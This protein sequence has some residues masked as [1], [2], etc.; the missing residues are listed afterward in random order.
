MTAHPPRL[1]QSDELLWK[2]TYS[3]NYSSPNYIQRR[4][5]IVMLVSG[6]LWIWM[7]LPKASVA[8]TQE[9]LDYSF[10]IPEGPAECTL[11]IAAEQADI[12]LMFRMELVEGLRTPAIQGKFTV[13]Q[14]FA[15]LLLH[16]GLRLFEDRARGGYAVI[17]SESGSLREPNP[18]EA[19][20]TT[21]K[22]TDNMN[23]Y[24][25]KQ[26][27]FLS[28]LAGLVFAT[29]PALTAQEAENNANFGPE[30]NVID[31]EAFVVTGS[32]VDSIV[33]A[34]EAK[35][36]AD[37]TVEVVSAEDI[38]RLPDI[39]VA[40][41]LSRLPGISSQRTSGQSS[42]INIRGL[43]QQL[44]FATLNGREQVTQNGNRSVEFEQYP[45]ELLV[46]AKVYKSPK[47]SLIEG[48]IGGTIELQTIRPLAYNGRKITVNAR[49]SYSDRAD[50][51]YGAKDFGNRFSVSY[52]DQ[53][54]NKTLGIAFGYARLEQ[55]DIASRFVGF[56]FTQ[57]NKDFDMD[58][59]PDVVSF[60]FDGE[61]SGGTDR[62]NGLMSTIQ[63]RP[64]DRFSLVVDAYYSEFSSETFKRQFGTR[65][66]SQVANPAWVKVED[67]VVIGDALVGGQFTRL[68]PAGQNGLRVQTSVADNSDKDELLSLGSKFAY[69]I[70]ER[71]DA[72]VDISYSKA[73]SRA[74]NFV[75]VHL[76]LESG[77]PTPRFDRNV[78]L[79]F[80]LNGR[81]LPT[82]NSISPDLGDPESM[83]LTSGNSSPTDNEDELFAVSGDVNF[84]L[85]GSFISGLQMGFRYSTRDASQLRNS[86]NI[87]TVNGSNFSSLAPIALT[88]ENSVT[89][90]FGGRFADA[91]FPSFATMIDP[92][93]AIIAANGPIVFQD[94]PPNFVLEGSFKIS[95]DVTAG[96][97][98]T[99]IDTEFLGV[100]LRG[101][102]GLRVVGTEQESVAL[103][104]RAPGK[105]RY[106]RVLPAANFVFHLT[107]RDQVRLA[108]SR[109]ITRPPIAGLGAGFA[110]AFNGTTLV[111][112]GTGNP[113]LVPFLANQADISYERY[114]E[115]GGAF[116]I[117]AFYKNL[118]S[119]IARDQDDSFDFSVLNIEDFLSPSDLADWNQAGSPVVG[120]QNGPVNGQGGYVQGVEVGYTKTFDSLPEPFDG[121]GIIANYSYTESEIEFASADSGIVRNSPL[122]GLST[123]VANMTLFYEK[124]GFSTRAGF[125][126]RSEFVSPQQALGQQLPL[127]D[128]ETVIDYQVSYM[129]RSG[130]MK[131]LT[132]LLQVNNLTDEPV[133]TY[134]GQE[135]QTGT[136]QYFGRQFLF[137]A[138]YAF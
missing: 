8:A 80:A 129:F 64:T 97:A 14:A 20:K 70:S 90:G 4:H 15:K 102:I 31:L 52:V 33:F 79:D 95:E 75:F 112:G 59:T 138:S 23:T 99:N 110:L 67:P 92:K 13:E 46:G 132:L 62:R 131:G 126:Y 89:L 49:G 25:S 107:E 61:L 85:G 98:Q 12:D 58:G 127:T 27:T 16:S 60:G 121:F 48:G 34:V 81:D 115:H 35:K 113:A 42:A 119:F 135:A 88:A 55:P 128:A 111:G 57:T 66:F 26:R 91:G 94:P 44:T 21:N 29:T 47:A 10:S 124:G 118:E 108:A 73:K 22:T 41:S 18:R 104:S 103:S 63:W 101:N 28:A 43:S 109:A 120:I 84:E 51:I 105:L 7:L 45:S 93:A 100:P 116:A 56:D 69:A 39:S 50:E 137:G 106:T 36:Y 82:I 40:D 32:F 77:P 30:D 54:L 53:F 3:S 123:H 133:I 136:I 117:G 11:R 122:P 125:R 17:Q 74:E 86:F 24:K 68:R 65:V 130:S 96:Y 76:P 5:P 9:W 83:Y 134:F 37:T 71:V 19:G 114:F 78:F 2:C 1:Y 6:L 87:G 38:G 72:T